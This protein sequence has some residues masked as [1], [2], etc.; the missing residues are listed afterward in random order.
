MSRIDEISA[1]LRKDFE[2]LRGGGD[3]NA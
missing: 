1:D 2:T 3:L